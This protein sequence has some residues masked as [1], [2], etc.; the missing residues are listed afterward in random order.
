MAVMQ[1]FERAEN[2][3]ELARIIFIISDEKELQEN[4][5]QVRDPL[6]FFSGA[7]THSYYS[8]F[9]TAKGYL[10]SKGVRTGPP[11]EHRKT[12][13][14]FR[15]IVEQG[16]LD[17]DLLR[18]YEDAIE[19]ANS[20]LEIFRVERKKRGSFTYQKLSQAN[21]NPARTSIK[22]AEVFFRSIYNIV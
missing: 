16:I 2:E 9:Y 20:L 6:S 11:E 21:R 12:Y 18:I 5:F 4:Y 19:R 17:F 3:L 14:E 7:I 1:Y 10:M 15:K 8:I 22:N 13:E